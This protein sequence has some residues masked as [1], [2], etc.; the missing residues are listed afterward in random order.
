MHITNLLEMFEATETLVYIF[1]TDQ[2]W[3]GEK[4]YLIKTSSKTTKQNY[5]RFGNKTQAISILKT[6]KKEKRFSL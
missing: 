4:L 5:F 3:Q 2:E 1:E 6:Y